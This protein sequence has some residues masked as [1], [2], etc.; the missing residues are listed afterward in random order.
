MGIS[1]SILP[2]QGEV[3][4]AAPAAHDGGGGSTTVI[5]YLPLRRLRRHLPLA[6]EDRNSKAP[7]ARTPAG[8]SKPAPRGGKAGSGRSG[9]RRDVVDHAEAEGRVHRRRSLAVSAV[10]LL[11]RRARPFLDIIILPHQQLG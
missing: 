6:G 8:Q 1:K 7:P 5:A 2:R 10:E 9:S 3:S 11:A 4:G